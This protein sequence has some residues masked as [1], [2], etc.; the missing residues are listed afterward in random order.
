MHKGTNPEVELKARYDKV[1]E[2]SNGAG[3]AYLSPKVVY[4][5]NSTTSYQYVRTSFS[6]MPSSG[7]W[8]DRT[9]EELREIYGEESG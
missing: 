8:A 1:Y 9:D 6:A 7:I 2:E 4:E 3:Y 5:N